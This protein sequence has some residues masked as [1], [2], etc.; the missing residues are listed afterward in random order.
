MVAA[1]NMNAQPGAVRVWR[2][3]MDVTGGQPT[4][5]VAGQGTLVYQTTN[6]SLDVGHVS[7]ANS[8]AGLSPSQRVRLR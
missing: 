4:A 3:D 7:H 6:W 8:V 5:N 1:D 2:F